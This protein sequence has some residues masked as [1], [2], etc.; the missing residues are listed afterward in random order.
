MGVD[1]AFPIYLDKVC[2]T[3]FNSAQISRNYVLGEGKRQQNAKPLRAIK[4]CKIKTST[5]T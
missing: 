5:K 4:S 2:L 1:I 3:D